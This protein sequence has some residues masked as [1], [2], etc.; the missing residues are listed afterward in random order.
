MRLGPA[1]LVALAASATLA[2]VVAAGPDVAKQRVA[3]AANG[4]LNQGTL[5]PAGFGEFVLTPLQ[6][7]ALER[8][9]GTMTSVWRRVVVREGQRLKTYDALSTWKGERG[10]LVFRERVEWIETGGSYHAGPGTWK[11]VRGTGQ[12]ARISGGGRSANVW[13]ERGPWGSRYEGYLTIP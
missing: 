2:S 1:G 8:D 9:S 13:L 11:V 7:G 5:N 6:A 3:V 4:V 12:Y 10:S